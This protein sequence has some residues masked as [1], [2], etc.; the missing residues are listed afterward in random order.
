MD[1]HEFVDELN[2][3]SDEIIRLYKNTE[4]IEIQRRIK[5]SFKDDKKLKEKLGMS[6]KFHTAYRYEIERDDFFWI[7]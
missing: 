3:N 6:L 2:K 7:R 1:K 4:I 5:K